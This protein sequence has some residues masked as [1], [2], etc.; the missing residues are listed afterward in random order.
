MPISVYFRPMPKIKMFDSCKYVMEQFKEKYPDVT[1]N[2]VSNKKV[3]GNVWG[4][5]KLWDT[6]LAMHG[7]KGFLTE[8]LKNQ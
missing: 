4:W 6:I 3:E 1:I 5:R 8:A 2:I 7:Q